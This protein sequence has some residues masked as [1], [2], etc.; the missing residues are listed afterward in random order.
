MF[1]SFSLANWHV[2]Q[3]RCSLQ[4]CFHSNKRRLYPIFTLFLLDDFERYSALKLV[5]AINY[6]VDI[7][8]Q[9]TS[10]ICVSESLNKFGFKHVENAVASDSGTPTP[11]SP[12]QLSTKCSG[13][14]PRPKR[15]P[16]PSF[17]NSS[18]LGL[19]NVE[20]C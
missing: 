14:C 11:P 15:A 8:L 16:Q 5:V 6:L 9:H 17:W 7:S 13:N 3:Q 18:Q 2:K 12:S 1:F 10:K 4:G 20:P 19:D